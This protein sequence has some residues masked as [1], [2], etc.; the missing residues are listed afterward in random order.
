MPWRIA[1]S[2]CS[3]SAVWAAAEA[4]LG[5]TARTRLNSPASVSDV[6]EVFGLPSMHPTSLH[7]LKNNTAT[8]AAVEHLEVLVKETLGE[9][10]A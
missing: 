3:V 4:G 6:G 10:V 5:I 7:L 8:N 2:S 9:R 1:M